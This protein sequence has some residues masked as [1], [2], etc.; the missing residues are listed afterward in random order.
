MNEIESNQRLIVGVN[1]GVMEE[2]STFPA[3]KLNPK[4][5]E[6][7]VERL[8]NLRLIRN[9]DEV[10]R[11]L[12]DIDKAALNGEN[13]FPFVI[14]AVRARATLGEIMSVLKEGFGTYMA[15]SGF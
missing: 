10:D 8:K 15:P 11:L 12:S 3:M 5:G 7:Q 4:I 6:E 1:H 9:Q 14:D 13:L 2:Q